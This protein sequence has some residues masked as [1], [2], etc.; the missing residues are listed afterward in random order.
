MARPFRRSD[1]EGAIRR[2]RVG[3]RPAHRLRAEAAAPVPHPTTMARC[4]RL[5]TA[6]GPGEQCR[7]ASCGSLHRPDLDRNRGAGGQNPAGPPPTRSMDRHRGSS[8]T[9]ISADNARWCRTRTL[10]AARAGQ[11]RA[12]RRGRVVPQD[13]MAVTIIA[14]SGPAA[15]TALIS[16]PISTPSSSNRSAARYCATCSW[17]ASTPCRHR[18][19]SPMN[20]CRRNWPRDGSGRAPTSR[21]SNPPS[22]TATTGRSKELQDRTTA[23]SLTAQRKELGTHC[24]NGS[25]GSR[26]WLAPPSTTSTSSRQKLL[27]LVVEQVLVRLA[28]RYQTSHPLGGTSHDPMLSSKDRLR[29]LDL[30]AGD[31]VEQRA[32]EA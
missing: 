10:A 8:S 18:G 14:G 13:A 27:R 11:V 12:L 1:L 28:R 22:S 31:A 9:R 32:G 15:S 25:P 26:R 4:A 21:R 7:D 23:S 24:A 2:R 6:S 3:E 17:P 20:C 30:Q 29:S 16:A 19:P 5:L